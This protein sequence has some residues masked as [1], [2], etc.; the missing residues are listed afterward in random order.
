MKNILILV[1]IC[2]LS[3]VVSGTAIAATGVVYCPDGSRH[4][5]DSESTHDPCSS[6]SVGPGGGYSPPAYDY[7]AERRAQ[8]AAAER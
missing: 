7:E 6:S 5:Q 1:S 4:I 8:A 3:S 2:I